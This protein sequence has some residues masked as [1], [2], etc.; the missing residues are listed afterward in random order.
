MVPSILRQVG[1]HLCCCKITQCFAGWMLVHGLVN[2]LCFEH[3]SHYLAFIWTS[4]VKLY[5]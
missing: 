3:K 5:E 4:Y 1:T 2:G